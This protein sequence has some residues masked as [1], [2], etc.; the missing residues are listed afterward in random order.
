MPEASPLSSPYSPF[1]ISHFRSH[2][3]TFSL[4]VRS[5]LPHSSLCDNFP[6]CDCETKKFTGCAVMMMIGGGG[7][8]AWWKNGWWDYEREMKFIYFFCDIYQIHL[9]VCVCMH[10]THT[11]IIIT[12]T[13]VR[14]V[15]HSRF[16]DT[17]QHQNE[18]KSDKKGKKWKWA[19]R[20]G[21]I[22]CA[23]VITH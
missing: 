10:H 16:I 11:H 23:R 21:Q 6:K 22:V 2:P 5:V 20:Q 4:R 13:A 8:R 9:C 3:S 1:E 7:G 12:H 19:P 14:N 18:R 17:L 15:S